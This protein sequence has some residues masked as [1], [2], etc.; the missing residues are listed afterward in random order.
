[1]GS[2]RL[3]SGEGESVPKHLQR[4][5][6]QIG[7]SLA[8][9]QRELE[10]PVEAFDQMRQPSAAGFGDVDLESGKRTPI[11]DHMN[12]ATASMAPDW[13]IVLPKP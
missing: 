11:P 12:W 13:K 3:Q 4:R 1:M 6:V 8:M 10:T 9:Q 5:D 7:P 2:L